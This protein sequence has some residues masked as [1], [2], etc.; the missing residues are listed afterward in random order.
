MTMWVRRWLPTVAIST[1]LLV[2]ATGHA[3]A[4]PVNRPTAVP[5]PALAGQADP[6]DQ[7]NP[8]NS[9]DPAD[10]GDPGSPGDPGAP[11]DPV[12][13]TVAPVPTP[14]STGSPTGPATSVPPATD[15]PVTGTP[16]SPRDTEITASV[17]IPAGGGQIGLEPPQ[18][19][20]G[21][22]RWPAARAAGTPGLADPGLVNPGLADPGLAAT[23]FA[24]GLPLGIVTVLL[25]AGVAAVL[26]GR[27]RYPA[28]AALSGD[29]P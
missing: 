26:A 21:G 14:T 23:G 2:A 1:T 28:A 27:R 12:D 29:R 16:T 18:P 8:A 5:E 6:A 10:P 17:A 9:A 11:G 7:A 22:T 19:R 15:K 24:A 20:Q 4:S 3:G 25:L 13:P